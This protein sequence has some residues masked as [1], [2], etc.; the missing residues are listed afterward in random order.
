FSAAG[1]S[2]LGF[3]LTPAR[4]M[5]RGRLPQEP[6]L[7]RLG[8]NAETHLPDLKAGLEAAQAQDW[9]WNREVEKEGERT[10]TVG[11]ADEGR[12]EARQLTL[13]LLNEQTKT[14]NL[15]PGE[16]AGTARVQPSASAHAAR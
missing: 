14:E 7:T 9:N 15:R 1:E 10:A 2:D 11:S 16:V 4:P 12:V 8:V 6:A 13:P 5:D 3:G